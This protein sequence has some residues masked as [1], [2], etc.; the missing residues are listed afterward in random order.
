MSGAVLECYPVAYEPSKIEKDELELDLTGEYLRTSKNPNR[1]SVGKTGK[2]QPAR[3]AWKDLFL[4]YA[5][6]LYEHR[7]VILS[8]SRMFLTPLPFENGL[9][10]TGTS[11]LNKATL[12][13]YLEWWETCERAIIKFEG[14]IR[15]LTYH[16]AGSPLSGSNRC[17]AVDRNG[18]SFTIRFES[19][20]TPLWSSFMRINQRY[21]E[22]KQIYQA[23]TLEETLAKLREILITT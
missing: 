2:D 21:T 1:G 12:G 15:A 5:F 3:E 23:Y 10:Y 7:D 6:F 18:R 22:A 14:E 16:I 4:K 13:V 11:G 17:S 8:D 19:P 9:A 20:F